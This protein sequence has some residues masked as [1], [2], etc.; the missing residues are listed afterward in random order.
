MQVVYRL[1][2][3]LALVHNQAVPLVQLLLLCN[4]GCYN[5]QMTQNSLVLLFCSSNAGETIPL[6]GND[7]DVHLRGG[8]DVPESVDQFIV[9]NFGRGNVSIKDLLEDR[10]WQTICNTGGALRQW[11]RIGV[12]AYLLQDPQPLNLP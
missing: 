10:V 1:A 5:H 11:S 6:L 12:V 7:D 8:G 2:A 4:G 3:V 9:V